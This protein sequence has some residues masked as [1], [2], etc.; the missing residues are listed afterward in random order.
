MPRLAWQTLW[1][2]Q[3]EDP[4]LALLLRGT[5]HVRAARNEHRWLRE[6]VHQRRKGPNHQQ[7]QQQLPPQ[8]QQQQQQQQ[9]QASQRRGRRRRNGGQKDA[10]NEENLLLERYCQRRSTGEPLQYIIG[11]QPFGEV[12]ISCRRGVLIPRS[13]SISFSFLIFIYRLIYISCLSFFFSEKKN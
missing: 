2:L 9:P 11:S 12:D 13:G 3:H 10:I 6:H 4:L 8:R 7:Q 5:R 1:N